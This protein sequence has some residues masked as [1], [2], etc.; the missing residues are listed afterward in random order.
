MGGS[1]GNRIGDGGSVGGA[2][3]EQTERHYGRESLEA[4]R[5]GYIDKEVVGFA[6]KYGE[7]L[8]RY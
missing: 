4:G 7:N 5:D 2:G 6:F 8:K 1:V 3:G